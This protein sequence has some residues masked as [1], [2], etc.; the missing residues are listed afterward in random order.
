MNRNGPRQAGLRDSGGWP[1][2]RCKCWCSSGQRITGAVP[3]AELT[4]Q[5]GILTGGQSRMGQTRSRLGLVARDWDE[6]SRIS[7][8]LPNRVAVQP[9]LGWCRDSR[10]SCVES[11]GPLVSKTV[12]VPRDCDG[13]NVRRE[14]C[15][16]LLVVTLVQHAVMASQSV[17]LWHLRPS[18]FGYAIL[19]LSW[20]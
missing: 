7:S 5:S 20:R 16:L 15:A 3:R 2:T 18:R 8:D 11:Q 1:L 19:T 13:V 9:K 14:C 17:C 12:H 6:L 10:L 4:I